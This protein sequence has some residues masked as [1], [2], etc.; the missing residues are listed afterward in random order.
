MGF[1]HNFRFLTKNC[2]RSP[3]GK[4]NITDPEVTTFHSGKRRGSSEQSEGTHPNLAWLEVKASASSSV[5]FP[6]LG[7]FDQL[8][9][10][11]MTNSE[12]VNLKSKF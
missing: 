5:E 10:V 12:M 6:S 9:R 8:H 1:V 11:V 4:E 2:C 7:S 3:R